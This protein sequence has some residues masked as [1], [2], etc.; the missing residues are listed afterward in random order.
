MGIIASSDS[1]IKRKWSHY[2]IM[3]V[4]FFFLEF[5]QLF[6]AFHFYRKCDDD[7]KCI[8]LMNELKLQ[9]K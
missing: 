4:F 6:V 3:D 8:E 7:E 5:W 9:L 2:Q 1:W